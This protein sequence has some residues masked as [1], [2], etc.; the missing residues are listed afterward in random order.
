MGQRSRQKTTITVSL[1]TR[2]LKKTAM[3]RHGYGGAGGDR[4][5]DSSV[6]FLAEVAMAV[7]AVMLSCFP[8]GGFAVAV[9]TVSFPGPDGVT[10]SAV[11]YEPNGFANGV[12]YP[13]VVMLHGCSGMWSGRNV[14]AVNKD[15][16]PNLQNHLEKWGLKLAGLG[17]VALAVDSFTPRGLLSPSEQWQCEGSVSVDPHT[18]RVEDARRAYDYLIGLLESKVEGS[19]IALLGWN[20]GAQAAM[21]EVA[22][23]PRDVNSERP[24]ADRRYLAA[25]CFYPECGTLLG[26]G[27][28]VEGS[29][30]RPYSPMQLHVGS[31]DF[32]YEQCK[33]RA[34]IAQTAPYN[35]DLSFPDHPAAVHAFDGLSQ[36]WPVSKCDGTP[37]EADAQECAMRAADIDGLH[38][39]KASLGLEAA[40]ESAHYDEL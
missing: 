23:T 5:T 25:L 6:H 1:P 32:F 15:G 10:L 12:R 37:S 4:F 28:T 2:K 38:F 33:L 30:W 27:E 20:H 39:F 26:F 13:A 18:T 14:G 40:T 9:T 22:A 29:F 3:A 8:L 31:A 36:K 19:K 7:T 35:A 17:V 16:T 34:E 21:V 24:V 11:Q